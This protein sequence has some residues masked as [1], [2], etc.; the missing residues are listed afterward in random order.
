MS[1]TRRR[2]FAPRPGDLEDLV[3]Q[4]E[5]FLAQECQADQEREERV[6]KRADAREKLFSTGMNRPYPP[7][8]ET[9][10]I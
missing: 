3:Q 9:R 4:H 5:H 8:R 6:Q 7:E 2:A 1:V 10:V